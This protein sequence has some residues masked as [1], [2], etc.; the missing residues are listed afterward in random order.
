VP[1]TEGKQPL[2]TQ[3]QDAGLTA[4]AGAILLDDPMRTL[5]TV[6]LPGFFLLASAGGN[7]IA[8][9]ITIGVHR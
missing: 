6:P 8:A 2:W 4:L 1:D 9:T 7:W 5:F 3:V